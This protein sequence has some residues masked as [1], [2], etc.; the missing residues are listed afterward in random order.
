VAKAPSSPGSLRSPRKRA[1]EIGTTPAG[2]E[3]PLTGAYDPQAGVPVSHEARGGS[4]TD[5]VTGVPDPGAPVQGPS[6]FKLGV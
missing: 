5:K 2:F 4:Y 1:L 6:P 3:D